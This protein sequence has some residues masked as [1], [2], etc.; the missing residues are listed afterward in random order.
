M[1]NRDRDLQPVVIGVGRRTQKD[2]SG[3]KSLRD[4]IAAAV[5]TAVADAT[6]GLPASAAASLVG[7]IDN[8]G[9]PGTFLDEMCQRVGSESP[10][11][12]L[13]AAV[14]R[15]VGASVSV[16]GCLT[17]GP[18]G[19]TPQAFVNHFAEKIAAGHAE[20]CVVA[21]GEMMKTAFTKLKAG[22]LDDLLAEWRDEAGGN[23]PQMHPIGAI[24][25]TWSALE[26]A[27]GAQEPVAAYPMLEQA[28]RA[29][30]G[31]S[32]REHAER[33]AALC[34]GMSAVAAAP[35]NEG[36]SWFAHRQSAA[37]IGT[38]SAA[39]RWV[40]YPY[41]KAMNAMLYVD[42]SAAC[43]LASRRTAL[44]RPRGPSPRRASPPSAPT[45]RR[46]AARSARRS[47]S[48]SPASSTCTDA[49]TPTT[50]A[51]RCTGRSCTAARARR[52]R[53]RRR[54]AWRAWRRQSWRS[55]TCTRASPW[56]RSS[57]RGSW[58][59]PRTPTA[60]S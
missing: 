56:R 10:Y 15:A 28:L 22:E 17:T 54:C 39:N 1:A 41:T 36:H 52:W 6:H 8:V 23:P 4:L 40:G 55:P 11:P 58:A 26:E 35:E 13:P 18:S 38:V 44:A 2:G 5:K 57:P 29:H 33:V 24:D 21:G 32:P 60:P 25:G 7:K 45:P 43:I 47:A 31:L 48:P 9:C 20:V 34:A 27:N 46:H 59:S 49:A 42:Q 12:N 14:A 53:A 16:D 50:R 3:E 37:E 19:N 30:L 51:R